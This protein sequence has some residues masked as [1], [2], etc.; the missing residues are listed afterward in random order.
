MA[1]AL[2]LLS[3]TASTTYIVPSIFWNRTCSAPV[4]LTAAYSCV[5][6]GEAGVL[7]RWGVSGVSCGSFCEMFG[8]VLSLPLFYRKRTSVRQC[9]PVRP[10]R[11]SVLNGNPGSLCCRTGV[12]YSQKASVR[13]DH[14]TS[15]EENAALSAEASFASTN[16]TP[17]ERIALCAWLLS[18]TSPEPT[19]TPPS[20]RRPWPSE[21]P[22]S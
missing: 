4:L 6:L 11:N 22:P 16:A 20:P 18:R 2:R 8:T 3:G 21:S 1:S 10:S 14:I 15:A 5:T 13:V 9:D 17:R 7:E 12:F 19:E